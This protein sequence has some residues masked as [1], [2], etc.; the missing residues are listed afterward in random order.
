MLTHASRVHPDF[1]KMM[2]GAKLIETDIK[3][4]MMHTFQ[5]LG[6]LHKKF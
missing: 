3:L 4:T 6:E 2:R 1:I 5:L